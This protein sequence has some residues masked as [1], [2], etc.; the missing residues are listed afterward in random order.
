MLDEKSAI[1]E[2]EKLREE[3]NYHN[4]RYY[5]LDSPVIS[6]AEY[7]R[8]FKKLQELEKKFPH[9]ITPDSPTQRVGAKP[10]EE[11]KTIAHTIPMLSLNNA[12]TIED[13][14][15]FDERVKR[16][17]ET[18]DEI[19]YVAEP[20]MDGLAI[21]V[22]YIN[23]VFTACSTRGDGYTG[24]DV[25]FNLK[26]VKSIPLRLLNKAKGKVKAEVEGEKILPLPIP[27][28]L[29]VR[30]E[31]FI[32]I[33][34]FERLNREREEKGEPAFANP[35]NAAAGS[36][37]QL[38]SKITAARPLDIYCYGVGVIEDA[39]FK[40]HYEI[41]L[42]L[43]NWGLKVNPFIKICKGID[44]VIKYH[45]DM[46]KKRDEIPY[47]LDGV[48]VKVNSLDLQNR[49]GILTR[50]PRWAVAYKFKARQETT[51]VK[52]IKVGVGRT[53][54]LTPVAELEP[55]E[56]GGVTIERAT[57]HNQDEV[58]RKDV[59]IGDTV[60][61]QRAGDVIPEV[62]MV[63]KDKRSGIEKPFK[64]PDKCHLCGSKVER[65][66]AIHYCT[67]GLSCP[68]QVKETIKHFVSKRAMDIEGLGDKHIEQ[69]V[70][71]GLIKD[72]ADLY[73]LKKGDLLKLERWA[74]KSAD[75]LIDAIEKSKRPSLDRLIFALGIRGV[76]EH[77]AKLLA[78]RFGSL[79]RLME[80]REFAFLFN[81]TVEQ[82]KLRKNIN[83]VMSY[84][85][86]E[87][88]RLKEEIKGIQKEVSGI[89]NNK[90]IKAKECQ[91]MIMDVKLS[92]KHEEKALKEEIKRI[93]QK[94]VREKIKEAQ[95]RA[96]SEVGMLKEEIR[97]NEVEFKNIKIF[98]TH[99]WKRLI[100][101]LR[102]Y[103]IHVKNKKKSLTDE[104]KRI[105]KELND[106]KIR[107][108]GTET[109]QSILDFFREAHNLAVI[110]KLKKAGVKSPPSPLSQ[111]GGRGDLKFENRQFVLTG[112]LSGFTRGEAKELIERLGG[113]VVS[114]VSKNTDYVIAGAEPGSK[115]DKAVEL[116]I[117]ILN[118]EEFK[119]LLDKK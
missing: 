25:T 5:I 58:D 83:E 34:E 33:K 115:Y 16:F 30:G 50:S 67:G 26:T 19:E 4:H 31:V 101:K 69:F 108:I 7:D 43:K 42:A 27:V 9:L 38:D 70:D 86:D 60:V 21:E 78:K 14:R 100:E 109:A 37:R 53:G 105:Q 36:I 11:F 45:E 91:K 23:G 15:E 54:A 44:E 119:D 17:L 22:I 20:K 73:Y 118:E 74:E 84:A 28:R 102:E 71:D 104:V 88:K 68:A 65:V 40:T 63:I 76:G 99:E 93:G 59:R 87:E 98:K 114:T 61:V 107:E 66:G 81:K 90:N 52:D 85:K 49:L 79:D 13:T 51:R 55:V 75:N 24:E 41:L 82:G 8:L 46:E 89:K 32:P 112:T 18:K 1:K 47:E 95:Q 113:R 103:K 39:K 48:V 35:R 3:I 64:L 72:L 111:R 97:R 12:N 116:G 62:V 96:K 94:K 6:D 29:E 117:K 57:L 92:A 110:E 77:M 56:V 10:L 2:L 80:A 106:L